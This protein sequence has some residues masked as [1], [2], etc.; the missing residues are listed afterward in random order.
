MNCS[1]SIRREVSLYSIDLCQIY[2]LLSFLSSREYWINWRR[3]DW[4]FA[5]D[6]YEFSL[7]AQLRLTVGKTKVNIRGMVRDQTIVFTIFFLVLFRAFL[8]EFFFHK[9]TFIHLLDTKHLLILQI[10][11]NRNSSRGLPIP[12]NRNWFW[13][14]LVQLMKNVFLLQIL[15]D[16]NRRVD[17][18]WMKAKMNLGYLSMRS[19]E[20]RSQSPIRFP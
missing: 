18:K 5:Y 9:Q 1:C 17:W 15:C 13:K 16:L 6:E 11:C 4:M 14:D 19:E 10:A 20:R 2:L 12:S 3:F 7:D 8:F